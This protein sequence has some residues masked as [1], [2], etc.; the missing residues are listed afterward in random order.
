MIN[1]KTDNYVFIEYVGNFKSRFRIKNVLVRFHD[2]LAKLSPI[3]YFDFIL[4]KAA[5][6]LSLVESVLL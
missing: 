4:L 6:C 2:F 5:Q 3:F 1:D